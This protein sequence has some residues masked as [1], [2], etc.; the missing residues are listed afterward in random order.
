MEDLFKTWIIKFSSRDD[1]DQACDMNTFCCDIGYSD[2]ILV[3]DNEFFRDRFAGYLKM[4]GINKIKKGHK[5]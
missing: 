3:Y 5:T 2:M 4:S 1:F